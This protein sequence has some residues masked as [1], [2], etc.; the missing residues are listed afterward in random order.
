MVLPV[1]SVVAVDL[2]RSIYVLADCWTTVSERHL[3]VYERFNG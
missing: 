3:L 2:Y 1:R